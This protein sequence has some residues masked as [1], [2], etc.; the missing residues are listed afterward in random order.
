[1]EEEKIEV[2]VWEDKEISMMETESS[3]FFDLLQALK[4]HLET[5]GDMKSL[6]KMIEGAGHA[7]TLVKMADVP[8]II[9]PQIKERLTGLM[10]KIKALIREIQM[11]VSSGEG[12]LQEKVAELEK[13]NREYLILCREAFGGLE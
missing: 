4:A 11:S 2:Q 1:M 5:P 7:I 9:I 10:E 6:K 13:L 3:P 12:N 8:K